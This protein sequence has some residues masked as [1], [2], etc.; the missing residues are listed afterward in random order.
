MTRYSP[1]RSYATAS[2]IAVGFGAL[3]AWIAVDHPPA[4]I[5]A[6]LFG[7]GAAALFYLASRPPIGICQDALIIGRRKIPWMTIRRVDR[8]GWVS[9]LAVYIALEDGERFLLL[10]PGDMDSANSLLRHIRRRSTGALIDNI[11]YNQFWGDEL[12]GHES[13]KRLPA[14]SYRLLREEDED[15]VKRL[16]HLLKTVG[17]LD[18]NSSSEEK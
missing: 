8:T 2:L 13:P 17:H 4:V 12:G 6:A 18:S 7:I 3:S 9:P 1:S 10:Y 14:P 15:E 5:A 16:Y 11:P